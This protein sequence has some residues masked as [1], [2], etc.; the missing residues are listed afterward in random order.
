MKRTLGT[1]V[2][3]LHQIRLRMSSTVVG[4]AQRPSCSRLETDCVKLFNSHSVQTATTLQVSQVAWHLAAK[5]LPELAWL[6]VICGQ[7]ALEWGIV[8]S[9]TAIQW[10]AQPK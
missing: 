2:P 8:S 3:T 7:S 10:C 4:M 9:A 5:R 1:T 6:S